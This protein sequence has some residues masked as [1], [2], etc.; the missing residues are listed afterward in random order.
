[1]FSIF[2]GQTAF[3]VFLD[4]VM[5]L[6]AFAIM[7][8][9]AFTPY[10]V[11]NTRRF[12]GL[13]LCF[14]FCLFSF[15]GAD[16]YGYISEIAIVKDFGASNSNM[17]RFYV[18]L[19][20]NVTDNYLLFRTIIWGTA[21]LLFFLTLRRLNVKFDTALLLF[22]TVWIIWFSYAR[23]SLAMAM[24]FYGSAL[25]Y[26]PYKKLKMISLV[27]GLAA[28]ACSFFLHKTSLFGI[29]I[30]F[31]A[32]LSNR[33]SKSAVILCILAFPVFVFL[34]SHL[35]DSL[36]ALDLGEDS[37]L[38]F[39]AEAGAKHLMKHSSG[40]GLGTL[41]QKS[42]EHIPYYLLAFFSLKAMRPSC[43]S[44]MP[45]DIKL[46]MRILLFIVLFGSVFAFDLG[47]NTKVLYS[48]FLRYAAIPAVVVLS[49]MI[50]NKLFEKWPH[51]IYYIALASS[52]YSVLYMMYNAYV[53]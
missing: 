20:E 34:A 42:L 27:L 4:V 49:Y 45:K 1:M 23:A 44:K 17:E 18:W 8:P 35:S 30:V 13:F 50:E 11:N 48:R 24:L 38:S 2:S 15:W 9:A 51:R 16:W 39:Y 43:Y 22:S 40:G 25:L 6:V 47:V 3:L 7:K 37:D 33:S 41:V 19:I 52:M 10:K 21:L 31:L 46:F 53:G 14:L 28:I 36:A 32:L 26:R 29:A 5:L 12:C